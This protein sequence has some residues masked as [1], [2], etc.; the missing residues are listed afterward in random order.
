MVASPV[1]GP[2]NGLVGVLLALALTSGC[3][4]MLDDAV[5]TST[6]AA[7]QTGVEEATEPALQR[8]V[9]DSLD[10]EAL[11]TASR[12]ITAA[13][14]DGGVAAFAEP[15]RRERVAGALRGIDLPA[16]IVRID[17]RT[18][19]GA[20]DTTVAAMGK[21]FDRAT[22]RLL[23]HDLVDEAV[24]SSVVAARDELSDT[25]GNERALGGIARLIAKEAT[26]GFQDAV[27]QAR[28]E[29]EAGISARGDGGVLVAAARAAE[30]YGRVAVAALVGLAILGVGLIGLVVVMFRRSRLLRRELELR[31]QTLLRLTEATASSAG[32]ST[33]ASSTSMGPG[34]PSTTQPA[35]PSAP[36]LVAAVPR[37][38]ASMAVERRQ[39][40]DAGH[41]QP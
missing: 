14:V 15:G 24:R 10:P 3:A 39:R 17:D 12:R 4:G 30:S 18:L 23:V 29:R 6:T 26:L 11:E 33:V 34:P 2:R 8:R 37:G 19:A 31:D 20:V 36:A 7:V 21:H 28:H 1:S 32:A 16:A 41:V 40:S 27:D 25:E 22:V 9:A 5:R 13:V 38:V 35:H